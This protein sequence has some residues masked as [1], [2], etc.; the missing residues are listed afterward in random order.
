LGVGSVVPLAWLLPNSR[1]THWRLAERALEVEG[2]SGSRHLGELTAI[3]V[4]RCWLLPVG[5]W[6]LVAREGASAVTLMAGSRRQMLALG[7]YV[8]ART[9]MPFD[10]EAGIERAGW[11][12]AV[13]GATAISASLCGIA[14]LALLVYG[15]WV[16]A[17]LGA[18]ASLGLL[19]AG[20]LAQRVG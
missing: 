5:P 19:G 8:A 3:G 10:E 11:R 13:D 15:A 16:P 17:L 14:C 18:G 1:P 2:M 12:D 9:G 7:R 6:T 4:S 20:A